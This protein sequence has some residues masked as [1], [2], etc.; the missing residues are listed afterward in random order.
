MDVAEWF[1]R[2]RGATAERRRAMCDAVAWKVKTERDALTAALA[3]VRER[4]RDFGAE[5]QRDAED[6]AVFFIAAFVPPAARERFV[7]QFGPLL[8][9]LVE[10]PGVSADHQKLHDWIRRVLDRVAASTY[11]DP[12]TE[13][14]HP[15]ADATYALSEAEYADLEEKLAKALKAPTEPATEAEF[16]ARWKLEAA[17]WKAIAESMTD[18]VSAFDVTREQRRRMTARGETSVLDS[19]WARAHIGTRFGPAREPAVA[20]VVL[21]KEP[22]DAQ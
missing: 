8:P 2:F 10:T 13:R 4:F 5:D 6:V 1:E 7:G 3:K 15:F 21:P 9:R 18:A 11:E 19:A 12:P 14:P 16:L 20:H 22:P 17:E